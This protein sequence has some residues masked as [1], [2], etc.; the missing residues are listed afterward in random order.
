M[1]LLSI[2]DG[3]GGGGLGFTR[4]GN[5]VSTKLHIE[6]TLPLYRAKFSRFRMAILSSPIV[7]GLS[8]YT[9]QTHVSWA[10]LNLVPGVLYS[11]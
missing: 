7:R 2:T 5:K 3:R 10:S 11:S 1:C 9:V 8:S 6:I 4:S